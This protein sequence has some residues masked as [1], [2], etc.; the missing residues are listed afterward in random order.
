MWRPVLPASTQLPRNIFVGNWDLVIPLDKIDFGK[1][2]ATIQEVWKV[3]HVWQGVLVWGGNQVKTA[4]ITTR[5]PWSIFLGYHVKRRS[6]WRFRTANN[7]S[8]FQP[9]EFRFDDL[10]FLWI[11]V[12]GLCENRWVATGVDV[13]LHAVGRLGKHIPGAWNG[14]MFLKQE[15]YVSRDRIRNDLQKWGRVKQRLVFPNTKARWL[16]LGIPG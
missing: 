15:F 1:N 4:V 2:I 13:M 5:L 14:W 12:A 10:K 6:Q 16:H 7:A 11:K 3:L 8:R 9:F